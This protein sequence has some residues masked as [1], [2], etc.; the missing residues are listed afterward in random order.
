[1]KSALAKEPLV[2]RFQILVNGSEIPVMIQSHVLEISVEKDTDLPSMFAFELISPEEYQL[3]PKWIDVQSNLFPIG[4]DVEIWLGHGNRL[5]RTI[6]A[7]VTTMEPSFHFSRRARLMVRGYDHAHRLLHGRHTRSFQ[8]QT[9][10][11][12]VE[13]I[14][15]NAGLKAIVSNS[16]VIHPY[17]L[18]ANQRDWDF[19][20][21]RAKSIDYELMVEDA[22]LFFQPVGNS[23]K[24][25][26]TLSLSDDLLEFNSRLSSLRQLN[27]VILSS[28]DGGEP[29][30]NALS[31]SARS[32]ELRTAVQP[33][34]SSPDLR[35]FAGV[36]AVDLVCDQ[37]VMSLAE[38]EQVAQARLNQISR[39]L[40]TGAAIC[41]GRPDL[42]PGGLLRIDDV[43]QQFGGEYYVRSVSHRFYAGRGYKTHLAIQRFL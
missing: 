3:D 36:D 31:W 20:Q 18:Q 17:V 16:E 11:E 38:A 29:G 26:S 2:P 24:P 5:H 8:Q 34:L 4:S 40:L 13:L 33:G 41:V 23:P 30:G 27:E 21:Q 7:E 42:C 12:I 6:S 19:L 39:S 1:M 9:D 35:G 14:A 10:S 32:P 43:G 15:S 37:P 25:V 22:Q 28:W